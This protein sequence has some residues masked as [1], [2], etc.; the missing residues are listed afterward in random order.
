MRIFGLKNCDTCRKAVKLLDGYR[1]FDV[2]I[3]LIPD[4]ILDAAL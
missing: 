1:F 2:R 3:D 4:Q